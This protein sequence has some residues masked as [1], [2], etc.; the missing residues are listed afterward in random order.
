MMIIL[1]VVLAV[2]IT[3]GRR[4]LAHQGAPMLAWVLLLGSAAAPIAM[5]RMVLEPG[6][7]FSLNN[8]YGEREV[9]EIEA[10]APGQALM[11]TATL[12]DYEDEQ[13]AD[14]YGKTA[15]SLTL[16][17]EDWSQIVSGTFKRKSAKGGQAINIDGGQGVTDSTAR[18]TGKW[19]EDKQDRYDLKGAGPF[20]V[21]VT[22]WTGKAAI[23]IEVAV[24]KAPIPL[25]WIWI[26]LVVVNLL[27]VF[28][29]VRYGTDR[30][31]GDIGLLS[32]FALFLRDGVTPLDEYQEVV[33]AIAAAALVGGVAV[34]GVAALGEKLWGKHRKPIEV[35]RGRRMAAA[36]GGAKGAAPPP[37]APVSEEPV[38]EEPAQAA[39]E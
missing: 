31:S 23:A 9:V 33:F 12:N 25:V 6:E 18:K 38:S 14:L 5:G 34:G 26:F 3:T 35:G 32:F 30:I 20:K 17:G 22:N 36:R 10:P 24:V 11:V 4:L 15:Y 21:S 8:V 29:D 27:A 19:G 28:V 7:P 16:T 1:G 13:H 39:K 37:E 2:L